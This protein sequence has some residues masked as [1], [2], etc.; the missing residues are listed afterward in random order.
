VIP[1]LF[2]LA[3]DED[4]YVR[5]HA[6]QTL[7]WM[8]P[9]VYAWC[10]A[11]AFDYLA[12]VSPFLGEASMRARALEALG[13]GRMAIAMPDLIHWLEHGRREEAASAA[14]ALL[15]CADPS[16]LPQLQQWLAEGTPPGL[17]AEGAFSLYTL[18]FALEPELE[19]EYPIEVFE[20]LPEGE[21]KRRE[22]W[23]SERLVK[24][25]VD[26]AQQD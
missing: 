20:G 8:G 25:T 3:H 7:S 13:A 2:E 1:L 26:S 5:E 4:R 24:K 9:P 17:P 6:L 14:D 16:I 19:A 15:R 10:Q 11:R 18:W 21:R 22:R 23:A 12:N